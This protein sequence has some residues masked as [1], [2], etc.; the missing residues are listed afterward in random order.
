MKKLLL[1]RHGEVESCHR[2][3]FIGWTDAELS[4]EGRAECRH[5]AGKFTPDRIYV[6]PLR[7]AQESA[8]LIFPGRKAEFITDDRLKECFFGAYEDLSF[9]EIQGRASPEWLKI[10]SVDPGA[11]RFPGGEAFRDFQSRIDCFFAELEDGVNA[12]VT[13]G[14][15]LMHVLGKLRGLPPV[16]YW[17]VLPARGSVTEV[18][19]P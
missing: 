10:W 8:E 1:I 5:L 15:V 12:V 9:E 18:E 11:V 16:R 17:E 4:T 19:I 13:H 2:H 6:S 14:G 3:R 7:R